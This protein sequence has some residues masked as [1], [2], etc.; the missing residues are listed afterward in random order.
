MA[1]RDLYRINAGSCDYIC[2]VALITRVSF[3]THVAK[4]KNS[5]GIQTVDPLSFSVLTVVSHP[6]IFGFCSAPFP[7]NQTC[8]PFLK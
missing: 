5:I 1:N 7:I 2:D 8:S 4:S 3:D 6:E